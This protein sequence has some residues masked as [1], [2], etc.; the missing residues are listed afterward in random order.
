MP[1]DVVSA[2]DAR[3]IYELQ[4][5][6]HSDPLLWESPATIQSILDHQVSYALVQDGRMVGYALVQKTVG[7]LDEP[8]VHALAGPA[9]GSYYFLRD[10]AICHRGKGLGTIL[11]CFLRSQ[12]EF[13]YKPLPSAEG[14]WQIVFSIP[15]I[16]NNAAIVDS[17]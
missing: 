14:F 11:A 8:P 7:P 2:T 1:L 13:H 9:L 12:F 10:F 3:A 15:I 16:T 4:L 6:A 5:Q 17:E